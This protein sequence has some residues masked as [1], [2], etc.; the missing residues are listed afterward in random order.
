[1][2]KIAQLNT[3]PVFVHICKLTDKHSTAY[4]LLTSG[5]IL[6]VYKNN[7]L[8]YSTAEYRKSRI[9]VLEK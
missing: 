7:G 4:M 2:V 6:I 3:S 9:I 8:N 1:M 5:F